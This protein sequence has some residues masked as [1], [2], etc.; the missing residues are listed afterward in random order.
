MIRAA[1]CIVPTRL[2][3]VVSEAASKIEEASSACSA[4]FSPVFYASVKV[5]YKASQVSST[6]YLQHN[7]I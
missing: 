6:V 5:K 1:K 7:H 4:S 2:L 3:T